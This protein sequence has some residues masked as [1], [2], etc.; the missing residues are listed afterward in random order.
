MARRRLSSIL[1]LSAVVGLTTAFSCKTFDLPAET[2]NPGAVHATGGEDCG[3][4][5]EDH[6][7]DAVGVCERTNDPTNDCAKIVRDTH[8]CVL[9]ADLQG[10][11]VEAKCALASGLTATDDQK[12]LVHPQADGAYRC[13]RGECGAQCGLPVCKVDKAALLIRNAKCDECFAGGCCAPLNR[14]Y[15]SRSCKLMLECIINTCGSELG[16]SLN[17][18]IVGPPD[19]NISGNAVLCSDARPQNIGIPEC[20]RTCLC[21]YQNNDQ[22]LPVEDETLLPINLARSVYVCGK[23]AKCGDDCIPGPDDA[24]HD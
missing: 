7:C 1:A 5:L 18:P 3:R 15:E 11:R 10:A 13:M 4:C 16:Q 20:V 23:S 21:R 19:G 12:R 9:E 8:A 2:C 24:G 6:C 22:G 17:D 14:C